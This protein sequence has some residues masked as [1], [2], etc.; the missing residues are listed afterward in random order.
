MRV[1]VRARVRVRVRSTLESMGSNQS[2][3]RAWTTIAWVCSKLARARQMTASPHLVRVSV[4]A[5]ASL[6]LGVRVGARVR[7]R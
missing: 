2:S 4:S 7:V 5:R 1:R 6:R 3:A